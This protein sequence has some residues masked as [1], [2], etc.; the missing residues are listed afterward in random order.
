MEKKDV[1]ILLDNGHGK[2]TAGKRSPDGSILEWEYARRVVAEV[3]KRLKAEGYN[4]EP[5]TPEESDIPLKTRCARV[6]TMCRRFGIG[7]CLLVSVHLNASGNG[8][9]W[10]SGNGWQ[11]CISLNASSMSKRLAECLAYKAA[12]RFRVRMP[13]IGQ[14]YWQQ[15]LAIC[16]DTICPAVLTENLFM[17][18]RKDAQTLLSDDGFESIVRLH[19]EGIKRFVDCYLS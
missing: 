19:Y 16:R 9:E 11:A 8:N 17:D 6:N 13:S 18:N 15:N 14:R 2:E 3:S 1:H 4:V 7:K 10:M 5:V 12:N